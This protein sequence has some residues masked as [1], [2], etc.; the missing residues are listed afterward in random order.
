M[1]R[2]MI[3]ATM[4]I[5][6]FSISA[7]AFAQDPP[8]SGTVP[9]PPGQ[10]GT[11][12][13]D[14]EDEPAATA[15]PLPDASATETPVQDP[16]ADTEPVSTVSTDSAAI[17]TG[18]DRA[19]LTI[20]LGGGF[21]LDPFF[22]SING[23]G[24]VDA[25]TLD[26]ACAGWISERPVIQLNWSGHAEF[27]EAFIYSDHN[28]SLVIETPD[29]DFLCNDDTNDLL[30]DP[31][32][33]VA[34]PVT[35]TYNIWVGNIDNKGLIPAVLVLTSR[36]EINTGTFDLQ[37]LVIRPAIREVILN[38]TDAIPGFAEIQQG[39]QEA[40]AGIEAADIVIDAETTVTFT[41]P[42]SGG[43]PG[44][45]FPTAEGSPFPVC[46][47]IVNPDNATFFTLNEEVEGLN[48]FAESDIDATLILVGPDGLAYCT[49]EATDDV[50]RNPQLHLEDLVPGNYAIAVGNVAPDGTAEAVV[51]ISTDMSL[52]PALLTPE[53][54][55]GSE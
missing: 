26:D 33:E 30:L 10:I 51:T 20:D 39:L 18:P 25:S 7:I 40:L 14:D 3:L 22:V 50:N 34:N 52:N 31:T 49:D 5:L 4:I 16:V 29:G 45:V 9:L 55:G 13:P 17:S 27:A 6:V 54:I 35:G 41:Q 47:G 15:T 11:D 37:N 44:F 23:G 38:T 8:P 1:R 53:A 21:V 43:V 2:W 36:S 32:I 42:I 24:S 46:N 19:Y 48:I 28:P 12:Q